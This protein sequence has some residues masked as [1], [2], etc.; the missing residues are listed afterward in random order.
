MMRIGQDLRS[1]IRVLKRAPAVTAVVVLSLGLGIG[2][3]TSVFTLLNSL[4]FRKMPVAE[5][6]RL[7]TV[8]SDFANSR[9]YFAGAGWN[10][11]MWEKLQARPDLFDGSL[12]WSGRPVALG[13]GAQSDVVNG[14][15]VSGGFF[16]TLGVPA[17]YGRVFTQAD[18][19]LGGGVNG[20]V[21]V[22]SHAFWQRR[23]AGAR[24]IIGMPLMI[25]WSYDAPTERLA[26]PN[27]ISLAHILDL[28]R[29]FFSKTR[30]KRTLNLIHGYPIQ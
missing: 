23:L 15:F 22:V 29:N 5:P 7:V 18:D 20:P 28:A 25:W 6:E 11:P 14:L 16:K 3:N 27:I 21:V 1:A 17:Q 30:W 12:A 10:Y 9:G 24:N 26:D 13:Q 19:A 2:A 8:S 4:L